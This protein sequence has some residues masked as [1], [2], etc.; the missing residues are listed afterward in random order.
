M[1]CLAEDPLNMCE[2]LSEGKLGETCSILQLS[3]NHM[4]PAALQRMTG[5][6]QDAITEAELVIMHRIAA[7]IKAHDLCTCTKSAKVMNLGNA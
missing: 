7:G 4:I 5:H 1:C 2:M 6:V 3:P